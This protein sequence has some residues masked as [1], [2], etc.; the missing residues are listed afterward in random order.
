VVIFSDDESKWALTANRWLSSARPDQE[1]RF[2]FNAL[3]PGTYYAIAMDYV[4]AGEWQD[5]EWLS[6]AAKKATKV[7]LDEGASKTLDLKL[8]GG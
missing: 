2:R 3:P 4:P 1:G 7:T 8:A 6:R 5:P